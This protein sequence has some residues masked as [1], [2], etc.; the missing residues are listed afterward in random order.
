MSFSEK[1]DIDFSVS[2]PIEAG[3]SDDQLDEAHRG[4]QFDV[5]DMHRLGKRQQFMR[6]FRF[7]SILGFTSTLMCTWEGWSILRN[8]RYFES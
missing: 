7:F 1:N 5:K 3:P 2:S 8:W 6:N 4:T